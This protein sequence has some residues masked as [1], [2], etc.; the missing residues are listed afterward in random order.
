MSKRVLSRALVSLLWV[1]AAL[2]APGVT[3]GMT[4]TELAGN[5]LTEYPFFEYVKAFNEDA[6]VDVAVDPIRFPA[7]VG[8]TCE[9]YVVEAKTVAEWTAD[10]TLVDV[11]AGGAMTVHFTGGSIQNNTFTVT[12][13]YE[14]NADAGTGLGVGYDVVI[15]VNRNGEL[16][17]PDF[18]DGYG[19]EAGL[20]AVHDVTQ[21][22][23]LAVTEL[24]LYSVG[25]VFGIPPGYTNQ[26]TFYPTDIASMGQLPLI[27]ISHGNGHNYT[28]Y[29]HLGFHLASYGY[30]VMSHQNNTGPGIETASSTT[31]GHTD[32]IIDQQGT[33]GGGVLNGH[34][35]TSR[36]IWIGHSRGAEGVARAYD[37]LYDGV[38]VPTHYTA[39]DIALISSMLPRAS[40]KV[41]Q[42][43]TRGSVCPRG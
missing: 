13:P 26:D 14:L 8:V 17:D 10:P 6:S 34:I 43:R 39:E 4:E 24:P 7:I 28:W 21:P 33:I 19:D 23:P 31:L 2:T 5:A 36:I 35:D 1:A 11:T 30:I 22:G 42:P 16:D 37:R 32:A 29:D 25:P 38:Y 40:D 12:T 27:V 20:Y 15:D 18:I 41:R 3:F 9:I